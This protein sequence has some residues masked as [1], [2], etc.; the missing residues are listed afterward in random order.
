MEIN[1]ANV[2]LRSRML[3]FDDEKLKDENTFKDNSQAEYFI[4]VPLFFKNARRF[5]YMVSILNFFFVI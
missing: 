4:K 3:C 5:I 2:Y 1:S